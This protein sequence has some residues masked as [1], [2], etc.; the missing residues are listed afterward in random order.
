MIDDPFLIRWYVQPNPGIS[1]GHHGWYTDPRNG[2]TYAFDAP[3]KLAVEQAIRM[4]IFQRYP[5]SE[6][7]LVDDAEDSDAEAQD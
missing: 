3:T 1:R 4:H 2:E 6:F 5:D 7:E